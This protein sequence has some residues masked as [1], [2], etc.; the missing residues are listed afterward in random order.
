[1]R[2]FPFLAMVLVPAGVILAQGKDMAPSSSK[3][4]YLTIFTA[5]VFAVLVFVVSFRRSKRGHQD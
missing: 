5:L 4:Q 1:M 3:E 2:F